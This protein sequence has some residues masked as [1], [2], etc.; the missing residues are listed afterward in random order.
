MCSY[1]V[2]PFVDDAKRCVVESDNLL[3]L[4]LVRLEE[5]KAAMND[6]IGLSERSQVLKDWQSD[7]DGKIQNTIITS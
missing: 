3:L 6:I 5:A 2:P 7:V 1:H 4:R